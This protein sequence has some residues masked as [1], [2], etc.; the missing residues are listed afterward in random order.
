[1]SADQPGSI[2][3]YLSE[4]K[5]AIDLS[6]LDVTVLFGLTPAESRLATALCDGASLNQYAEQQGVS[7]NT[8]RIQLKSIFSKTNTNRQAELIKLLCTSICAKVLTSS[9]KTL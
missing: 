6:R 3:L 5:S 4:H 7:S 9:P 1:M 2:A 8:A